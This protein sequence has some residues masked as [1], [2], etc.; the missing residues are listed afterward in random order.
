MRTN[1]VSQRENIFSVPKAG[2]IGAALGYVGTYAVPLTTEE[3][4]KYFTA[5][6]QQGIADKVKSARRGEIEAI[7]NE[8]NVQGLKGVV[9]DVFEKSAKALEEDPKGLLKQTAHQAGMDKGAKEALTDFCKRVYNSGKVAKLT[10]ESAVKFAAKKDNRVAA[11][12]AGIG[13]LVL[14]SLA[15][16]K[17]SLDNFLPKAEP[18]KKEPY[19]PTTADLLVEMAEVPG[20]IYIIE[21]NLKK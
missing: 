9:T 1:T 15:V 2:M 13:A 5:S 21:K 3:H 17:T 7:R 18:P 10:E 11:F 16:V 20:E 19:K 6:V 14:M 4:E 12:Y 8:I